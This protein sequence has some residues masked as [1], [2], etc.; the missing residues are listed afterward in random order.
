MREDDL[1]AVG[2]I[3][4]NS[5]EASQWTPADYLRHESHVADAGG[6]VIGF[7]VLQVLGEDEAE[8]LNLAVESDWRRRGVARALLLTAAGGRTFFLE[9]RESNVAARAFY[10]SLGFVESGRRRD[11]YRFPS[12]DAIL[13]TRPSPLGHK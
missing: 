13:L 9:V 12:E 11:Y 1:A 7:L 3:Q 8:V 2:A 5:P 6:R 4:A 10:G